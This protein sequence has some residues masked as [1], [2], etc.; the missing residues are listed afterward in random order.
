[1]CIRD[2]F[3][4]ALRWDAAQ[5]VFGEILG[6]L[7][8]GGVEVSVKVGAHPAFGSI[9]TVSLKGVSDARRGE[10]ALQVHE[11]LKPFVLRHEI[12]QH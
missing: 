9:A 11:R 1:M 8:A 12:A 4:P 5:L 6:D 10:L 7:S 3:K 2:R